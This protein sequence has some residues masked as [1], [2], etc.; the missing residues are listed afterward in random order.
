MSSGDFQSPILTC[1]SEYCI[2]IARIGDYAFDC[3]SCGAVRKAQ[4]EIVDED[5]HG[6]WI[7]GADLSDRGVDGE[8]KSVVHYEKE[9]YV[10]FGQRFARQGHALVKGEEPA[11][12]GR[13]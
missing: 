5:T 2:V 9:G 8:V 6:A 13:P 10:I 3:P 7:G 11:E 4:C 12:N 1:P